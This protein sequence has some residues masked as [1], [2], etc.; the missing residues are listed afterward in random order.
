MKKRYVICFVISLLLIWNQVLTSY[1]QEV[2]T[3]DPYSLYSKAAVL[4]DADSKRVLYSKNGEEELP[5]ASTTKIMTCILAL[6]YGDL[7]EVVEISPYATIQPKVKLYLGTADQ[8]TLG[9]LLY[10]LMLESHNDTAVAIAEHIGAQM[11]YDTELTQ[12][13]SRSYEE[14]KMAVKAFATLMNEKAIELGCEDT[15]YITP[16]GLDATEIFYME[17]GSEIERTHST[18]AADLATIMSYC[19]QDSVMSESFLEIT[20]T[21]QYSFNTLDGTRSFSCSNHNAFL[22]MMDGAISGKTGYTGNASYCY[23]GAV[24]RDGET[25]V[26][27]LLSC[28]TYGNQTKKWED[29]TKLM[30]YGIEQY[31][32]QEIYSGS[33]LETVLV[34]GAILENHGYFGAYSTALEVVGD[35]AISLLLSEQDEVDI[36]V[37]VPDTLVAPI[38]KNEIVGSVTIYVNDEVYEMKNIVT[39]EKIV[40]KSVYQAIEYVIYQFLPIIL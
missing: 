2:E 4:M 28:S 35:E 6:E 1:A 11:L 30:N 31:E 20:G 16:N 17:D 25:Y 21:L 5:M 29:T 37:E 19:I 27:A 10:S 33:V 32:E 13:T 14:S 22:S 8:V 39:T 7:E 34:E 12:T 40:R 36:V 3:I 26:V 38:D 18:T 24:K 23:V 9:D 15:Y